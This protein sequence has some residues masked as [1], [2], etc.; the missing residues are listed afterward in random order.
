MGHRLRGSGIWTLAARHEKTMEGGV[1]YAGGV[2]GD[3]DAFLA[4]AVETLFVPGIPN[5]THSC[6][7][8]P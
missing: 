3:N 4:L 2:G 6:I 5:L 8:H 1:D 7:Y